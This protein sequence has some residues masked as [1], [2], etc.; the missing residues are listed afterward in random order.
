MLPS[1]EDVVAPVLEALDGPIS[2]TPTNMGL[3]KV[4]FSWT[5]ADYG[6]ATEVNYSIEAEAAGTKVVIVSGINDT[7]TVSSHINATVTYDALNQILFND[8]K[9]ES[10]L[11][12]EVAFSVSARVETVLRFTRMQ[13]R[14]FVQ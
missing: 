6:V 1:A 3:E 14:F 7:T 11:E 8:L 2:I 12:E 9:L 4:T 5:P 10:G 13:S